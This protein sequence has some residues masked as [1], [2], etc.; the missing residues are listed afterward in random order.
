MMNHA[1]LSYFG[2]E[3]L[4]TENICFQAFKNV[5]QIANIPHFDPFD[6]PMFV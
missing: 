1:R 2:V 6:P 4:P 5:G 3:C